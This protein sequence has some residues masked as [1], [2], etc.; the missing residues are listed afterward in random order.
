[1]KRRLL[2]LLLC[3]VASAWSFLPPNTRD[4][5]QTISIHTL[6]TAHDVFVLKA[7]SSS[8]DESTGLSRRQVIELAVAGTGVGISVLGTRE[9][10]PT[11]Y[12]LWG[13]LPVGTYKTKKTIRETI[14]PDQVWTFDQKFGILD[15]QVPYVMCHEVVRSTRMKESGTLT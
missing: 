10:K 9:I 4:S 13:I 14:V 2:F 1:M 3:L 11:D 6:P 7:Q 12:G 5:P 15:V 8:D